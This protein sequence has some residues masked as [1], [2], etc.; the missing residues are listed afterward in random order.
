MD[1]ATSR[2]ER[3][4]PYEIVETLS[5]GPRSRTYKGV[6]PLSQRTVALKSLPKHL[7][8]SGRVA[9]LQ[10]EVRAATRLDHSGVVKVFEFGEDA[11]WAY[12]ATEIVEG[13]PLK[14]R[15]RIPIGDAVALMAQ[16][17]DALEY[18]HARGVVHRD[19]RP[20]NLLLTS[21]GLKIDGFGAAALE[22]GSA[23]Y[24]SPE[25]IRDFG[26]DGRCD[27]FSAGVIFYELLTGTSPFA[28]PPETLAERVCNQRERA[29]SDVNP[30]IPRGF[31]AVCARALAKAAHDRYATARA[32]NDAIREAFQGAHGSQ[33]VQVVSHETVLLATSLGDPEDDSKAS[34]QSPASSVGAAVKWDEATLHTVEKQ[35]AA[36]IGPLARILV[37]KAARKTADIDQLYS[38]LANNLQEQKERQA[39]LAGKVEVQGGARFKTTPAAPQARSAAAPV[40]AAPAQNARAAEP[41]PAASV[42]SVPAAKPAPK[43]EVA[44]A[45]NAVVKHEPK[46]AAE[47]KPVQAAKPE[48]KP[49]VKSEPQP[50][51]PAPPKRPSGSVA[52]ATPPKAPAKPAFSLSELLK[53][54]E[55][56]AGYL[57]DDPVQHEDVIHAFVAAVDAV[58]RL[59]AAK[60]RVA[61]LTPQNICFDDMGKATI[62]SSQTADGSTTSSGVVGNPRYAV[63]EIF[64]EKSGTA[65]SNIA[66]AHIYALG[67]MFYEILLGRKLFEK[68]FAQQRNDLDWLRWHADV[69]SKAPAVRSLLPGCPEALS[70]LLQ[71]M[72]EKHAEKRAPNLEAIATSFRDLARRSNKT[73][74]IS[75]KP[76]VAA[77]QK[78]S[79]TPAPAAA[80]KKKSRKSLFLLLLVILAVAAGAF[81]LWQNP[82]LYRQVMSHFGPRAATP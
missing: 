28:G 77:T 54:P 63:P 49:A 21:K 37:R 15:C 20:S 2:P 19:L 73:V 10:Q 38:K 23:H 7:L 17:L 45:A 33:P 24:L 42:K 22:T 30:A 5:H 43:I 40:S 9:R 36:F 59:H 64:S 74:V 25:Q 55:N 81:L 67:F 47:A 56:L 78:T 58:A 70:E 44:P 50:Q 6:E 29:A 71:S 72:M 57:T 65:E 66:A 26:V 48:P 76:V 3:I 60:A 32:F 11:E 35:L 52:A 12:V 16:L 13:W 34:P 4:G 14:E 80:P 27:V 69:E 82:E 75:R 41:R 8:D 18:A 1:A 61:P 62:A 68:T 79:I 39:F 53:Q 31:D 46:P 51:V